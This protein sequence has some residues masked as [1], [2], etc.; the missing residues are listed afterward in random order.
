MAANESTDGDQRLPA[1]SA[2]QKRKGKIPGSKSWFMLIMLKHGDDD[3]LLHTRR[4]GSYSN[5]AKSE[6][7]KFKDP[8]VSNGRTLVFIDLLIYLFIY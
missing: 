5:L 2:V 8:L 6:R 1:G 7:M 4:L 3:N